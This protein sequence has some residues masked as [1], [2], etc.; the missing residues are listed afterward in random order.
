MARPDDGTEICRVRKEGVVRG[1]KKDLLTENL[2]EREKGLLVCPRCQGILREACISGTGEH[3]C[4]S[5]SYEGEDT[6]PDI[7]VRTTV[8]FLKYS[9]PMHERGCKWVGNLGECEKHLE[10]CEYV[11]EMCK[12]GCGLVFTRHGL[13]IH[14]KECSHRLVLCEHCNKVFKYCDLPTHRLRC[15]RMQV[16]CEL[17]CDKLVIRE[18]MTQHMDTECGEKEVNCPFLQYGCKVG[19]IRREEM[20][21]HLEDEKFEHMVMKVNSSE[22]TVVKQKETIVQLVRNNEHMVMKVNSL[23]ERNVEQNRILMQLSEKIDTLYEPDKYNK[24]LWNVE[25]ITDILERNNIHT[26][27]PK[28]Y[29]LC[30]LPMIFTLSVSAYSKYITLRFHLESRRRLINVFNPRK[31]RFITRLVCHSDQSSTMEFKSERYLIGLPNSILQ[32]MMYYTKGDV[33]TIMR[34]RIVAKFIRDGGIELQI[35]FDTS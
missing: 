9:C 18:N 14:S 7:Q 23:E 20:N 21:R 33:A 11:Y 13:N 29:T 4:L 26:F 19:L 2:T 25:G 22:E 10:E 3:F 16:R 1:F 34:D 32:E 6:H 8:H 17:G 15:C 30:G 5:C 28:E 24:A 12:L 27:T 35:T 31:G